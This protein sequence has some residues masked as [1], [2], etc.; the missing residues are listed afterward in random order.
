MFCNAHFGYHS[1]EVIYCR[2]LAD[3]VILTGTAT[4]VL[5]RPHKGMCFQCSGI[6]HHGVSQSHP[7]RLEVCR[8]LD[9]GR[10]PLCMTQPQAF[11]LSVL[12]STGSSKQSSQTRQ[13]RQ[14]SRRTQPHVLEVASGGPSQAQLPPDCVLNSFCGTTTSYTQVNAT[15]KSAHADS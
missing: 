3:V 10:P 11:I 5:P 1:G 8:C 9:R 7:C 6:V 2:V 12:S 15:N 14:T 13:T 4:S